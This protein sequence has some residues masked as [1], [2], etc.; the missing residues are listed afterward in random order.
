MMDS[1]WAVALILYV[2]GFASV[3]AGNSG[4]E[5]WY[6]VWAASLF[7]PFGLLVSVLA[8]RDKTT[9]DE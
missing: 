3:F 5:K 4:N 2:I 1:G 6:V 7:W 9:H 8:P